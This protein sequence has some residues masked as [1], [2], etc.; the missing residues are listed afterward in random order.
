M[1]IPPTIPPAI[2]GVFDLCEVDDVLA[3]R[4]EDED[5]DVRATKPGLK[6]AVRKCGQSK[7]GFRT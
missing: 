2:A 7:K 4:S 1:K 5:V 6:N 3:G